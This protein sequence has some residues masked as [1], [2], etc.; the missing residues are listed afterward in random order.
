MVPEL[1]SSL[2]LFPQSI[3]RIES[4]RVKHG[5]LGVENWLLAAIL[6]LLL[7]QWLHEA[8]EKTAKDVPILAAH[9]ESDLYSDKLQNPHFLLLLIIPTSYLGSLFKSDTGYSELIFTQLV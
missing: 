6:C 2:F 4:N 1:S 8:R 9:P 7:P 3:K 5:L